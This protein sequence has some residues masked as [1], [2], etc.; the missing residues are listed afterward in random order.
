MYLLLKFLHILI[1]HTEVITQCGFKAINVP[2]L[3]IMYTYHVIQTI[4]FSAQFAN[5]NSH[6]NVL[7]GIREC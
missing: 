4:G 3:I 1:D 2:M 7:K 5:L 6:F